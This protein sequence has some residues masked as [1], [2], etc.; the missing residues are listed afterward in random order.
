M[1]WF[2]DSTVRCEKSLYKVMEEDFLP[3]LPEIIETRVSL[4][5]Y[6]II[7]AFFQSL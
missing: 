1:E 3:V 6:Y 2:K 7:S 5:I 4:A